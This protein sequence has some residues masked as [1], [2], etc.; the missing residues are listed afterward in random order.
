MPSFDKN[1]AQHTAEVERCV[2]AAKALTP[3]VTKAAR[4]L[5]YV[6][7]NS[8]IAFRTDGKYK[9]KVGRYIR[10][11]CCTAADRIL[12]CKWAMGNSIACEGGNCS[13]NGLESNEIQTETTGF[14]ANESGTGNPR[15]SIP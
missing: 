8:T 1:D 5:D 7:Q 11:N 2:K 6:L 4:L 3:P 10:D 9:E 12:L 15:T 13:T 14:K